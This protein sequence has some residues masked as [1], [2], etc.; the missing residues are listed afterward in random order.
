M[1]LDSK[2][3]ERIV[4]EVVQQILTSPSPSHVPSNPALEPAKRNT[5]TPARTAALSILDKVIT[6]DLLKEK[7]QGQKSITVGPR[8]V[9]TPSAHDFLRS[10][11]ISWSREAAAATGSKPAGGKWRV[12]VSAAGGSVKQVVEELEQKG[13]P[14]D[15][16]LVGLPAEAARQAVSLL[17]RAEAVGAVALVAEP[18]LVACLANR[19]DRVRAA[20][21]SDLRALTAVRQQLG[22][23]LLCLN[24]N[25]KSYFELRNLLQACVTGGVPQP[26]SNL[27]A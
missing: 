6:G 23:N 5:E 11:G 25:G 15:C 17:C 26:P 18:A 16:E 10:R 12:I 13:L 4:M 14:L 9:L 8:A 24:P 20:E 2:T 21:V 19:N 7:L 3:L 22:A 1:S 27:L